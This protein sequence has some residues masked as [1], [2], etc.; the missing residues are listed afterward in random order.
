MT[1]DIQVYFLVFLPQRVQVLWCSN[2]SSLDA[3]ERDGPAPSFFMSA[4]LILRASDPAVSQVR[5]RSDGK[6]LCRV[7]VR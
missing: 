6:I 4:L 5:D 1:A 2:D 3:C 7:S